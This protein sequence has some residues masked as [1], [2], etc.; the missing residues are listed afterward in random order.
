[1]VGTEKWHLV[2]SYEDAT[3][4]ICNYETNIVTKFSCFSSDKGFGRIGMYYYDN[5]LTYGSEFNYNNSSVYCNIAYKIVSTIVFISLSIL[6]IVII[7]V[8]I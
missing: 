3:I 1:M 8:L 4:L 2:P 6:F 5:L 7:T